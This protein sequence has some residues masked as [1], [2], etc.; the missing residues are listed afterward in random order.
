MLQKTLISLL[1][2]W[3]FVAAAETKIGLVD[4]QKAIESTADGQNAKKTLEGD[5]NRRKKDLEKD[6]A[7]I[8]TM[9]EDLE[10]K[11]LALSDE[12]K[13]KKQQQ[14]Q[15]RIQKYQEAVSKN[16]MEMQKRQNELIQPITVKLRKL[17]EDIGKKEAFTM[18]LEKSEQLVFFS[19]DTIDLTDRMVKEYNSNKSAQ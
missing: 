15:Q 7:E 16:Q 18:V 4:M 14:I 13:K 6:E 9:G 3:S 8:R 10:K 19:T 1:M 12:V 17:I 11:S 2:C 5:F